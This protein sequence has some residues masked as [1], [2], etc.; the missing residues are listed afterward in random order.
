MQWGEIL[1]LAATVEASIDAGPTVR[2]LTPRSGP[3]P[4]ELVLAALGLAGL[5]S[6]IG[7]GDDPG[8]ISPG[9]FVEKLDRAARLSANCWDERTLIAVRATLAALERLMIDFYYYLLNGVQPGVQVAIQQLE[10]RFAEPTMTHARGARRC[11]RCR[12]PDVH[13]NYTS[14]LGHREYE[15]RCDACGLYESWREGEP[16][17]ASWE[18]EVPAG[19]T[20]RARNA[21][22][23]SLRGGR[24]RM[25]LSLDQIETL[26]RTSASSI[27]RRAEAGAVDADDVERWGGNLD[28][29]RHDLAAAFPMFEVDLEPFTIAAAPV[30]NRDYADFLAASGGAEPRGWRI[31]GGDDPDLPVL[32]VSWRDATAFSR[33]KEAAL[34][35]EAQWER[36]ARGVEGRLFPWGNAYGNEGAWLD[37]Q[38]LDDAWVS[39]A[40]PELAT[41]EGCYDLVT[42]RWEWCSDTF[43]L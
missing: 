32:G 15:A 41:P 23:V 40:H 8:P 29:L 37:E 7:E 4:P 16:I 20:G 38:D 14:S 6:D 27:R 30:N 35:S 36:A 17:G 11:P 13:V 31:P 19:A 10:A 21:A 18:T 22:W 42:G 33:W 25:G 34:P 26:A 12:F 2:L 43:S 3:T 1:A 5:P 24:I 39:I 28:V 9:P